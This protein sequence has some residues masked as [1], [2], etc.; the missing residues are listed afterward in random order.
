MSDKIRTISEIEQERN[1]KPHFGNGITVASGFDLGAKSALDSRLTAKTLADRDA[2]VTGNRAYEGMIVYVE[3]TK[4][5]Y[6]LIDNAWVE[7]GFNQDKLEQS[8]VDN[9][10]TDSATS[11]LSARQ[12]KVLNEKIEAHVND[13][14]VHIT[15][16]ERE[17]IADTY[18]KGEVD[19]F[20]QRIDSAHSSLVEKV[21]ALE[22]LDLGN[23]FN[24]LE[25]SVEE[26]NTKIE[27]IEQD[28][29]DTNSKID[30]LQT[31]VTESIKNINTEIGDL[32]QEDINIKQSI[33]DLEA[34]LKSADS[35]L[36]GKISEALEKI[37]NV[38]GNVEDAVQELESLRDDLDAEI[39]RATEAEGELSARLDIIEG[40]ESQEGSIKKA[41]KDAKEFT[42]QKIAD[43]IDGAPDT[44]DTLKEIADALQQ[45]E[46]VV[47]SIVNTLATKASKEEVAQKADR[48]YVDD[49]LSKE[50]QARKE[51]DDK[52]TKSVSDLTASVDSKEADLRDLINKMATVVSAD[53][54]ED[55]LTG[56]VWLELI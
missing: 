36:D 20:V 9:L 54:P 44:L 19:G 46:G 47:G 22:D 17:K 1:V 10:T 32:K 13:D 43:L 21:E 14:D 55:R 37:S 15:T 33:T 40:E 3:E 38:E 24:D 29:T 4:K 6:Q 34:T 50:A 7:F 49:E 41:L 53:E 2:H 18:T 11:A 31:T 51:A 27:G 28:I 26:I 45:N 23:K 8:I 25:S 56:H 48:S 5:T 42:N 39:E 52:L 35:A 16:E 12:G 30:T